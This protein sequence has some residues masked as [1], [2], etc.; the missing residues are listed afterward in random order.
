LTQDPADPGPEPGQVEEKIGKEKTRCDSAT[1]P[2][3]TQLKTWLQHV[4]FF[5][6]T[7]TK[8]F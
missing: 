7:K 1:R 2:G 4:D 8:S 5:F 6:F 3:K